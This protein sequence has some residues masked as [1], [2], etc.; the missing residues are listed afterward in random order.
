MASSSSQFAFSLH[1]GSLTVGGAVLLSGVPS[2]VALSPFTIDPSSSDAPAHLLEQAT[3]AAG[4]GAFLGFTAPAATDRAPCRIGLLAGRRFLSVFHFKTWW[5]TMHAGDPGRDVQPETQWVLLDAPELGPGGC[6]FVL[7]LVQ[8]SFRSAIFPS[9]DVEDGL[10]LCAESG[11]PAVTGS[12]FGRIAYVHAGTDPYKVIREAYMAA[13]VHLGTFKLMEEKALPPM[14]ERFGWCTW[15]AFY[16]TVDPAG[17]WQG[18]SEFTDAGVPPR[19]IVID[20]GWQSANRDD[21]PPHADTPGLVLCGEQMTARLYRFDEGERFRRYREGG[22]GGEAGLKAFLKDMRQRFPSLDD[23]Y[24][25]QALCGSWGGVRPGTAALD[26]V[27]E[28]ARLSPG[29]AG[30]MD[31]LA[32]DRIVEGGIG[33]VQPQHAGKLYDAMHSYLAGA[34]VTGVKVDVMNTLEYVCAE[35]GG[36]VELAKAYY[37]GLSESV[38]ANFEGTGMIASMEQC[39]DFFFLGTRQVGMARAGDDFWLGN[40]DDAYWLQGVH[41]VNCS[42]NSLWMGQFVRPDWDM[43]QSD[44]VCAAFHGAS[45]AVSG[46]PIYVSNSLGCHD[47]ALL[48]TLVF[49]D[50]TLPLCL[51]YA[52]PT[53]DCLFKNPLSDQETVLKMWNLNKFGGV[54]GA[55]NCQGAGWDPAERRIRGHAHCYKPVSGEVHPTDVEWWQREETAGM[56]DAAEYAVYKHHSGELVLMTPQ[57][58]PIHFTL[59]P[60]SYEIFTFA[61][62]AGGASHFAPVGVVDMLNCGGTIADVVVGGDG[63]A[64]VMVKVKGAGRLVV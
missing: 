2:N 31:D 53:R 54:I 40:G 37:A 62:V 21:D 16:L 51:H 63:G 17:V 45:R 46:S 15:D 59:Q 41:M 12:D 3:A 61:P 25:W 34:G 30:T 27:V 32:V 13:R 9:E 39:N 55:F 43:F 23:V 50:G 24:V 11:S 20:D 33:L 60:S 7:P 8:G 5:S 44:H 19:F 49:P 22:D 28:P 47:F 18:V 4:R 1:D 35:H 6:V 26:T 52:L 14:A 42:Y 29:L 58:E 36:R 56:A 38:A 64:E 57:S 48:K 10:V